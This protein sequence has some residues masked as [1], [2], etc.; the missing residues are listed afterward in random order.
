MKSSQNKSQSYPPK[1]RESAAKL[2]RQGEFPVAATAREQRTLR[3]S[4]HKVRLYSL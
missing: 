4:P 1:F 3:A 2:A